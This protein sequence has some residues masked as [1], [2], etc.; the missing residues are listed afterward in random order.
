MWKGPVCLLNHPYMPVHTLNASQLLREEAVTHWDITAS[1]P[2][3]DTDGLTPQ[4]MALYEVPCCA[5]VS[6]EAQADIYHSKETKLP[7]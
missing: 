7:F 6:I 5:F 3:L 4:S 2:A 1:T